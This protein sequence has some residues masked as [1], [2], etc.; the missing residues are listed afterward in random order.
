[1][2]YL[3]AFV[4][5]VGLMA[6][7]PAFGET[8]YWRNDGSSGVEM[9]ECI[10]AARSGVE[11]YVKHTATNDTALNNIVY[12]TYNAESKP[13]LLSLNTLVIEGAWQIFCVELRATE[14]NY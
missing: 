6:N 4:I 2:K 1:M 13:R 5:G 14:K 7:G 3:A 10:E 9:Q 11:V 8:L 12:L